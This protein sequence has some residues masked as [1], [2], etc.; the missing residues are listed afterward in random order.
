MERQTKQE[1]PRRVCKTGT[2]LLMISDVLDSFL[3]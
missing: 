1:V 2:L 3:G